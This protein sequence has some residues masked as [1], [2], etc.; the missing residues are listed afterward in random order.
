VNTNRAPAVGLDRQP[1]HRRHRSTSSS[2]SGSLDHLGVLGDVLQHAVESRSA[3]SDGST[4]RTLQRIAAACPARRRHERHVEADALL[5]AR[6][7]DAAKRSL[8]APLTSD[9]ARAH[10]GCARA[11]HEAGG[12]VRADEHRARGAAHG[13]EFRRDVLEQLLHRSGAVPT[14]G[15]I[16]ASS[17][18]GWTSVDP[19]GKTCQNSGQAPRASGPMRS[20]S[21]GRPRPGE[22]IDE[23]AHHDLARLH[24][25]HPFLTHSLSSCAPTSRSMGFIAVRHGEE[26]NLRA[27]P[28][29]P[30]DGVLIT[31]VERDAV[32]HD[33]VRIQ[34]V[35]HWKNIGLVNTFGTDACERGYRHDDCARAP[36]TRPDL[37]VR[38]DDERLRSVV[39]ESS[40]VLACRR[41]CG[42]KV[43]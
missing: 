34:R 15:R 2:T 40:A 5:A 41:Q 11:S 13:A 29:Q 43:P 1:A 6:G 26:S 33:V 35:E 21:C 37:A 18:S 42:G 14:M 38:L 31:D 16:I 17:T 24:E 23:S 19:A 36:P 7:D 39:S 12:G 32:Q 28:Q 25:P 9:S 22:L 4:G 3:R 27:V 10:A 20:T 30:F 8:N